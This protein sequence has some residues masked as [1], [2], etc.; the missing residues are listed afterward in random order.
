MLFFVYK[1]L[2]LCI[3]AQIS[4]PLDGQVPFQE[5]QEK[6]WTEKERAYER[7]KERTAEGREIIDRQKEMN[8]I[9]D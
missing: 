8:E 6:V 5:H 7:K 1:S 2:D 9:K 4:R 3:L